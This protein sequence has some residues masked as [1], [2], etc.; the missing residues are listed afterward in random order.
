MSPG[1][2]AATGWSGRAVPDMASPA[3]AGLAGRMVGLRKLGRLCALALPLSLPQSA[4]AADWTLRV[5]GAGPLRVGMRFELVRRLLDEPLA[6]PAPAQF[7]RH[8]CFQLSPIGEPGIVLTFAAGHLQRVDAQARGLGSDRGV[9]I[10]DTLDKLARLY[11]EAL[12]PLTL[13]GAA[14]AIAEG[15][16]AAL[17]LQTGG[18]Q[19]G[20]RFDNANGRVTAIVSGAWDYVQRDQACA[21]GA[22]VK[23]FTG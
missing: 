11:G 17:A 4:Q 18:G 23:K 22:V 20:M 21:G 1:M 2:L 16:G 9:D 15:Q 3:Q 12:R 13:E 5:D 14:E 6:Q 7:G 10:D 8:G 19:Y